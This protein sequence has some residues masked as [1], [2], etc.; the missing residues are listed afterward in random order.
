MKQIT[1]IILLSFISIISFSQGAKHFT[2]KGIP[3][4]GEL[5]SFT[6]KLVDVGYKIEEI[7]N[8]GSLLNGT[9]AGIK[10]SEILVY[11]IPNKNV[12]YSVSVIFPSENKWRHL[13]YDY[14][15]LKE[16]L[17]KKY[18]NPIS[19]IEKFE[20]LYG[21]SDND[22]LLALE[23][24]HCIF[25]TFF[26]TDKGRIKLHIAS[27]PLAGSHVLIDYIDMVN[28]SLYLECSYDDL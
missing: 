1:T 26:E 20:E 14:F 3:I 16:N 19:C 8:E 24:D 21:D 28:Y 6:N 11:I 15:S 5:E 7:G 9:F 4:D 17:T 2:F 10:N 25:E 12:V 23:L 18:G 27:S 13:E 22:K